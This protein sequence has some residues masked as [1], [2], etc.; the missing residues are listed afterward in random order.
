MPGPPYDW[1]KDTANSWLRH[2]AQRPT[3]VDVS[4]RFAPRWWWV[5]LGAALG[6]TAVAAAQIFF[7]W[8]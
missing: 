7:P 4:A 5:A 3:L 2:P 6:G 8:N 1:A